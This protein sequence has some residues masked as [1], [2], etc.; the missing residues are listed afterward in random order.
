MKVKKLLCIAMVLS[1]ILGTSCQSTVPNESFTGDSSENSSG[2]GEVTVYTI[3][4]CY[5]DSINGI[6]KEIPDFM[7]LPRGVYPNEYAENKQQIVDDLRYYRKDNDTI[8]AFEGW[9]YDTDY[10]DK[11]NANTIASSVGGNITLY[12][13]IVEREKRN[14]DIVTASITYEWDDFGLGQEGIEGMTEG[15]NLPTEYIEGEGVSLPKLKTWKQSSKV[16]YRFVGWYYDSDFSNKL[17]GEL[18]SKTQT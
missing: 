11:L 14:G 6:V 17:V 4:Y 5:W 15:I 7:W 9:Y 10:T 18:I 12:A 16:S 2:D 3:D 1:M 13:K 8:Y